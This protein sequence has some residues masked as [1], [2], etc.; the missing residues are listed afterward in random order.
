M[1][2]KFKY[3]KNKTSSYVERVWKLCY[4]KRKLF[5]VTHETSPHGYGPS[6]LI[7][8]GGDNFF[9]KSIS[10][11]KVLMSLSILPYYYN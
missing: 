2:M 6:I 9:Y 10:L 8:F 3:L 5:E 1:T 11:G 4:N 7:Q